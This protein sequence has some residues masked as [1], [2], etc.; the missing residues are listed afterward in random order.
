MTKAKTAKTSKATKTERAVVVYT[1]VSEPGIV[2]D[3]GGR[4]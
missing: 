4:G 1:D 2:S 3:R